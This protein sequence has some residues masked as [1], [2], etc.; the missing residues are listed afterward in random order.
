[1][2]EVVRNSL[3]KGYFVS[4]DVWLCSEDFG[5]L[6]PIF[7]PIIWRPSFFYSGPL[8]PRRASARVWSAIFFP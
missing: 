2:F 4:G 8:G 3:V 7:V 6:V 5:L 1:M